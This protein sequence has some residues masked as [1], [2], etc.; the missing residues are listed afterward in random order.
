MPHKIIKYD[1]NKFFFADIV[2]KWLDTDLSLL[3]NS[4]NTN[5]NN[6][7]IGNDTVSEAHKSF[8]SKMDGPQGLNLISLYETFIKDVLIKDINE[9]CYFQSTPGFRISS[10]GSVAVSSWHADGDDA[11]LHPPGEINIFLPLTKCYGNNS[12]WIESE[13]NK[14]DFHPVKLDTGEAYI[15]DGNNCVHGNYSNDTI[16]TRVSL[17]FRLMPKSLYNPNYPHVTATK[18][19]SY[20]LG[21]YYSDFSS[22]DNN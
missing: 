2:S 3:H 12:M 16:H 1:I 4:Y 6:L 7:G 19:L 22:G 8:Y 9:P 20:V 17:D 21:Q 18:K 5:T 11:N 10:P 13:P 14:S 15:F